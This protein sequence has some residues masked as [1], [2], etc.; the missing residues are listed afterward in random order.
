MI[1]F[2][3]FCFVVAGAFGA[4]HFLLRALEDADE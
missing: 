1:G 2:I 4:I 3:M